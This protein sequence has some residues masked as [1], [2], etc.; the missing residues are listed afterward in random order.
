MASTVQT[1]T[2]SGTTHLV[3]TITRN[4]AVLVV[5]P[6]TA[7]SVETPYQRTASSFA[8]GDTVTVNEEEDI[9][10][11]RTGKRVSA[12]EIGDTTEANVYP[13]GGSTHK[14]STASAD[15]SIVVLNDESVWAV[16]PAGRRTAASW[17]HGSSI[18]V[19]RHSHLLYG[20]LNTD[21]H[22]IVRASYIGE[23]ES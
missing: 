17:A 1:A 20:L 4:G 8:S 11:L 15:G 19:P 6:G 2:R 21:D 9:T 22:T 3:E 12:T 23:E 18:A 7:Y 16:S 10:D 14:L 13:H 5:S